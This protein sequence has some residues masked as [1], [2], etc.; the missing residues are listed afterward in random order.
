MYQLD[1]ISKIKFLIKYRIENKGNIRYTSIECIKPT[2]ARG[3]KILHS[4][5]HYVQPQG[6]ENHN[7]DSFNTYRSE[8]HIHFI[9]EA[10]KRSSF[11]TLKDMS[12][13]KDTHLYW[14]VSENEKLLFSIYKIW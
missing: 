2:I 9:E 6:T 11:L 10:C 7:D 14:A 1:P 4:H 13:T 5:L 3:W 8:Q 12:R